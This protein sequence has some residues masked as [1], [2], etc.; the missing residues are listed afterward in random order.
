MNVLDA[1]FA[2]HALVEDAVAAYWDKKSEAYHKAEMVVEFHKLAKAMGFAVIPL[3]LQ[4]EPEDA[5]LDA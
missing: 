4:E 1:R 3:H 5:T 2:A